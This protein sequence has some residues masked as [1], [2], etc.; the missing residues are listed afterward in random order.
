VDEGGKQ[1]IGDVRETLPVRQG[2]PR[3]NGPFF[4]DRGKSL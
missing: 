4:F 1:L 3:R 2:T